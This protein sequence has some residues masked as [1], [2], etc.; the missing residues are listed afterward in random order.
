M[1]R[2]LSVLFVTLIAV[3]VWILAEGQTLRSDILTADIHFDAGSNTRAIRVSPEDVFEGHIQLRVSGSS[4]GMDELSR[5][6][7]DPI[8]L[9]LGVEI[10]FQS[11]PQTIDLHAALR[12]SEV[13]REIAVTLN[14][15]DPRLVSV[16]ADDLVT[17]DLPIRVELPDVQIEG[18]PRTDPGTVTVTMPR[19][20]EQALLP[21][22]AYLLA[23][24]TNEMLAPLTPGLEQEI[25]GIRLVPSADLAT[26]WYLRPT[27]P[28]ASVILTLR[29]RTATETIPTVPVQIR[30]AP[31]ELQRF[32][33]AVA[34]D[35]Q[36]LHD[37]VLRGPS[38]LIER[39]R[40][41]PSLRPVAVVTLSFEELERAI[42]SKDAVITLPPGFGQIEARADSVT[43]RLTITRRAS[44]PPE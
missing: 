43:V 22:T 13:F 11:G 27:A 29:S 38:P 36:F 16:D 14:E 44:V 35:D 10:P 37:V 12:R 26:S 20:V 17:V 28:H 1:T 41:D 5:R 31:A 2:V 34:E 4:A 15:V 39:I 40:S 8:T 7:R 30:V 23:V 32:D 42:A 19:S 21:G 3:L 33:I 25:D 18:T 9:Q 24:L 6:L